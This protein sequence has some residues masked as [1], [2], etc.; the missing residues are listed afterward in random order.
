MQP[1]SVFNEGLC[2]DS[3][4]PSCRD[5]AEV[6]TSLLSVRG[7]FEKFPGIRN[8]GGLLGALVGKVLRFE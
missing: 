5:V 1:C 8:F 7:N 3:L 4:M 2:C 6:V